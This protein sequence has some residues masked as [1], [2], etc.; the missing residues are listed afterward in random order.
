[1]KGL[2]S[3]HPDYH[4]EYYRNNKEKI[5]EGMNRLKHCDVCDRDIKFC[6]WSKHCEGKK[7]NRI[8]EEK[9]KELTKHIN[10]EINE[11]S[12]LEELLHEIKKIEAVVKERLKEKE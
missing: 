5:M 11:N 10:K 6:R 7:H 12:T 2:K 8:Q 1:M 9:E 4:K 3:N